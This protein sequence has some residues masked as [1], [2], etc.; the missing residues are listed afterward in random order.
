M[1]AWNLASGGT[2][3]S[4]AAVPQPEA[5]QVV[6]AA[7]KK[8][9]MAAA[10]ATPQSPA[11]Q[12]VILQMA[13]KAS[14]GKE[15]LLTARAAV[16]AFPAGTGSQEL[17][18]ESHM[19]SIVT[20]KMMELGTLDQLIEYATQYTVSPESARPFVQRMFQLG[21]WNSD[22][23]VWYRVGIVASRLKLGDLDRQARA[24]GDQLAGR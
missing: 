11:Q 15:L 24:R 10:A 12:G 19:R 8:L 20:A 2:A 9:Y 16:G 6:S 5:E 3:A 17:P 7:L 22:S 14:N 13:E 4:G 23:R 1:V 18:A 21:E